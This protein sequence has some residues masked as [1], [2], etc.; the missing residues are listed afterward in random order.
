M[1]VIL[2]KSKHSPLTTAALHYIWFM[3][4]KER[5]IT[6]NS[7]NTYSTL[8]TLTE[9]TKNVWMVFHGIGFLSRYFLKY[10]D[11]LPASENYIIA[12]QAPSKYYLN[13]QYKHVGASWLTKEKTQQEIENVL[14]YVDEVFASENIP[15]HCR[16]MV[17]GFSQGVSVALRWVAGKS[18]ACNHLVL[19]AGG[20]PGELQPEDFA[21]L[22]EQASVTVIVGDEDEYLNDARLKQEREKLNTLFKGKAEELQFEGGHEIKKELINQLI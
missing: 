19:Y 2:C 13:G 12:P 21:F 22:P 1:K 8:N 4:I 6:Y 9:N 20:V 17:F 11:E 15:E 10:F 3:E 7:R 16:L 18:V 14:N 5:S